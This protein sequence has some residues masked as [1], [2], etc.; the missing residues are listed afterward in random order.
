MMLHTLSPAKGSRRPRKRVG[1]GN[2]SNGGTTAGRGTKGQKARAGSAR[3]HVFEGGQTPLLMRQP[4]LGGF[5][6]PNRKEY[7]VINLADLDKLSAGS[8]DVKSLRENQL[9]R[10]KKPVKLLG[11]GEVKK[12]FKLT[13]NGASK[14]ARAAVESAGGSITIIK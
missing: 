1:R 3:K 4:K 5:T 10:T 14:T 6:N 12:K 11:Q 8:Y 7:E 2:S 13:V 9:I